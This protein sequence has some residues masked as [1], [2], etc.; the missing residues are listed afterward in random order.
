MHRSSRTDFEDPFP[1]RPDDTLS[2]HTRG[3]IKSE[4]KLDTSLF[5][6]PPLHDASFKPRYL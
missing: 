4:S 5:L 3:I 2:V 6:N 1:A